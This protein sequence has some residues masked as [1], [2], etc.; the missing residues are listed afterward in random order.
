LVIGD[1]DYRFLAYR[2]RSVHALVILNPRQRVKDLCSAC[3]AQLRLQLRR[4]LSHFVPPQKPSTTNFSPF[5]A[6]HLPSHRTSR[7]FPQA[8]E[9][10]SMTMRQHNSQLQPAAQTPPPD[11]GRMFG[12]PSR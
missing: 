7:K 9:K 8:G 1:C 3:A 11:C 6:L 5:N 10:H 4:P 12:N 2:P